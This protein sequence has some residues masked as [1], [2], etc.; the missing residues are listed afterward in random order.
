MANMFLE[1]SSDEMTMINGGG[2]IFGVATGLLTVGA[3]ALTVAF[4]PAGAWAWI[5]V[6]GEVVAGGAG[7]VAAF[8][9]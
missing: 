4:P 6:G 5:A 1:I 9:A 8:L 2:A 7:T 3:I